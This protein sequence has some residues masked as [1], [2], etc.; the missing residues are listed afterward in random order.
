M[1]IEELS[2]A[3]MST[4]TI[5]LQEEKMGQ[6]EC[7]LELLESFLFSST[8]R[9]RTSLAY[10]LIS[11]SLMRSTLVPWIDPYQLTTSRLKRESTDIRRL[12]ELSSEWLREKT[13]RMSL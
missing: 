13:M 1:R 11:R 4:L 8:T 6:L 3:F 10:S 7:G 5:F 9:K 12:R 2:L